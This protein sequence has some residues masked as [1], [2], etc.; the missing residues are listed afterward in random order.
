MIDNVTS[1][2]TRACFISCD[3]DVYY[4]KQAKLIDINSYLE[5]ENPLAL[6]DAKHEFKKEIKPTHLGKVNNEKDPDET[7]IN[8]IKEILALKSVTISKPPVYIPEQL[9]DIM[10]TLTSKISETGLTVHE[11]INISYG[12]KIRIRL[13]IK[14]AEINLFYGKRGYSVVISPRSGTNEEL[15]TVAAQLIES[16]IYQL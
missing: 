1:D 16:I 12:K 15:N 2:V 7:S 14:E 13:G 10:E 3:A 5:V 11:I 4:N 9:N 6:F 8:K